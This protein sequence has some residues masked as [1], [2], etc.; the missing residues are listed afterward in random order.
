MNFKALDRGELV[1]SFGGILL[2]VSLFLSWYSLGNSHT[3]LNNCHGP[4]GSCTGW[5]SLNL[6]RFLLLIA[7]VAPVIL[8]YIILRGHALSWPRGELTAVIALVA[9]VTTL[10]VGVID[11][12]GSPVDQISVAIGWWLAL[13]ASIMILAGS[14]WRS[15]EGGARR[16][17][18]GVL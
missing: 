18:P 16:K 17:P 2:G 9:L 7:A 3:V 6:V 4:N 10:F 11:K 5:A 8:A 14:V 15:R 13:V 12:P 1:A